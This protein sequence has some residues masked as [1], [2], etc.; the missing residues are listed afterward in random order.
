MATRRSRNSYILWRRSVT[1]HPIGMPA[2]NRKFA[3]DLRAVVI[4][5][6]WPVI[7]VM[8]SFAKS[9]IF[10]SPIAAPT[11]MFTVIFSILGIWWAFL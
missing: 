7:S 3:I 4:T 10:L 9:R 11:P 8:H 1:M 6:F 5:G 2:R